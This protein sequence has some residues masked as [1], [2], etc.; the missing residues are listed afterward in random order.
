MIL[1][2]L[3]KLKAKFRDGRDDSQLTIQQ[4]E[5]EIGE[6]FVI[7]NLG[8]HDGVK[9]LRKKI[10]DILEM[11]EDEL[12]NQKTSEERRKQ[13]FAEKAVYE[14]ID[15]VFVNATRSLESKEKEIDYQLNI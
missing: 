8:R 10:G 12:L 7:D 13:I 15:S 1:E 14:W 2:K 4:W 11:F 5:K 9:L 6:A 3:E